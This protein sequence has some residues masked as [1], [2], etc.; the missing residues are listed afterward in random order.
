MVNLQPH[1][2]SCEQFR[3]VPV[4]EAEAI[5]LMEEAANAREAEVNEARRRMRQ[6][7]ADE[8]RD[9][10]ARAEDARR[11]AAAEEARRRAAA[12]ETRVPPFMTC[13]SS[14]GTT[15]NLVDEDQIESYKGKI[16]LLRDRFEIV[17]GK[18]KGDRIGVCAYLD[19]M[20]RQISTRNVAWAKDLYAYTCDVC[21][22]DWSKSNYPANFEWFKLAKLR[23]E[24][25]FAGT[26][27]P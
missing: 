21:H 2:L 25:M 10:A 24:A 18:E 12:D 3:V 11:Q 7:E 4:T 27:P 17:T 16:G 5:K 6:M 1:K 20:D 14:P 26:T 23:F 9:R 22:A 19:R 15:Y 8:A 13:S